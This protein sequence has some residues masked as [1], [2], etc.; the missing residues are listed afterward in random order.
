VPSGAWEVAGTPGCAGWLRTHVLNGLS[1]SA[2]DKPNGVSNAPSANSVRVGFLKFIQ[3]GLSFV[4]YMLDS[5]L[6]FSQSDLPRKANR[7]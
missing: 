6:P 3:I 2:E 4:C 5:C 1:A 7:R